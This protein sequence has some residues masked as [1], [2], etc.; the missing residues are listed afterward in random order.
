ME[1]SGSISRWLKDLKA[2]D[3]RAPQ[4]LWER[5]Y[6][7]LVE[8][9][10]QRLRQDERRVADEEDVALS[11]FNSFFDGVLQHRFPQLADRNDLWKLLLRITLRKA[12]DLVQHQNRQ[13]RGGG[14]TLDD[15]PDWEHIAGSEPTPEFAMQVTEETE[16][17]LALLGELSLRTVAVMKLEGY[18]SS[19]IAQRL[20]CAERTVER[21]LRVI[22]SIWTPLDTEPQAWDEKS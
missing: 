15:A 16:R 2:G 14:R 5:Y 18:S 13:K 7:R 12:A 4:Q 6:R 8:L 10:R 3:S 17:L 11:A 19:E 20:G 22:R 9:A 1:S 21:K